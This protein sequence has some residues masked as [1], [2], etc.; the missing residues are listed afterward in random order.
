[1]VVVCGLCVLVAWWI[2]QK[3]PPTPG[4]MEVLASIAVAQCVLH[5]VRAGDRRLLV[6]TD[7]GGVKA[8]VELPGPEPEL[9]SDVPL[10]SVVP[11]SAA[12]DGPDGPLASASAPPTPSAPLTQAEILTLLLRLRSTRTDA[13]PPG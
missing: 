13:P 3:P 10:A 7:P 1:M 11:E 6:G 12:P 5:L 2:G 8:I 4:A 9:P